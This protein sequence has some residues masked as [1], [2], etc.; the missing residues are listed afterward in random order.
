MS[1]DYGLGT[2]AATTLMG[3]LGITELI[4]KHEYIYSVYKGHYIK[5]V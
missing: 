2:M 3:I 5:N 4:S 1:L